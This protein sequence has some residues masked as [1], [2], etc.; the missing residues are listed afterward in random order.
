MGCGRSDDHDHNI[1]E[2]AEPIAGGAYCPEYDL[3]VRARPP[4]GH[5]EEVDSRRH[6]G[7]RRS[8]AIPGEPMSSSREAAAGE[9]CH[10]AARD[11][12]DRDLHLLFDGEVEGHPGRQVKRIGA[13]PLEHP[14][15]R[16]DHELLVD[17]VLA[18]D[19]AIDGVEHPIAGDSCG[20]SIEPSAG[21][22]E[23]DVLSR[24]AAV[25]VVNHARRKGIAGVLNRELEGDGERRG[26]GNDVA[27]N[28]LQVELV[29]EAVRHLGPFEGEDGDTGIEEALPHRCGSPPRPAAACRQMS[30][31]QPIPTRRISIGRCSAGTV[32]TAPASSPIAKHGQTTSPCPV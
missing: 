6:P 7:P 20:A 26:A 19:P 8:F 18:I 29:D 27:G 4:S 25:S 30:D 17:G 16:G 23:D 2:A 3:L 31:P 24:L 11:V 22:G 10:R 13:R 1:A 5:G 21:D 15:A 32:S 14:R 28:G 9:R 12:M